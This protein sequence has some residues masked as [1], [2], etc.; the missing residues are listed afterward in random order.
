[1][2]LWIL[3][4]LS[5]MTTKILV[6]IGYIII[7]QTA[8]QTNFLLSRLYN[9]HNVPGLPLPVAVVSMYA[10]ILDFFIE[11]YTTNDDTIRCKNYVLLE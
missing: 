4:P 2:L 9:H 11:Y 1:M 6:T 7:V 5:S 8:C 3:P 10:I